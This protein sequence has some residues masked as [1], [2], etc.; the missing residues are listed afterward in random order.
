MRE[1]LVSLAGFKERN[2]GMS[3]E[4]GWKKARQ[5]SNEELENQLEAR[6]AWDVNTKKSTADMDP[7]Q[8]ELPLEVDTKQGGGVESAL[9]L[10]NG[11]GKSRAMNSI[12]A[13]VQRTTG[14]LAFRWH[15]LGA[16]FREG[17]TFHPRHEVRRHGKPMEG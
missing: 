1:R 5:P 11:M 2:K 8:P 3:L 10:A 9:V 14:L 15:A 12:L 16:L 7:K 4:V 17:T 13:S 6:G